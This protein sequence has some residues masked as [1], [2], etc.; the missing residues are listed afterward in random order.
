MC[1]DSLTQ[2]NTAVVAGYL[3]M[4]I[5]CQAGRLKRRHGPAEQQPVLEN[6][7]A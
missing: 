5:Y 2:G 3:P 4:S 7:A 1:D 6:P